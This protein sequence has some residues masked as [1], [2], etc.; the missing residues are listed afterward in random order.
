MLQSDITQHAH[1]LYAVHG[2]KAEAEAAQNA[3][4]AQNAAESK[5]WEKIRLHIKE[6]RGAHQT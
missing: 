4:N 6:M 3:R 2:D 5:K 1:A